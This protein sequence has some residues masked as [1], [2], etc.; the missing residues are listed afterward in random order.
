MNKSIDEY[1][2]IQFGEW[3]DAS[4]KN[5]GR[6][7]DPRESGEH[8]IKID[9]SD[10]LFYRTIALSSLKAVLDKIVD[11]EITPEDAINETR[12][13]KLNDNYTIYMWTERDFE[14]ECVKVRQ[15]L[16]RNK[17]F[18]V[19]EGPIRTKPYSG[20]GGSWLN[21]ESD[22]FGT[23]SLA[24]LDEWPEGFVLARWHGRKIGVAKFSRALIEYIEKNKVPSHIDVEQSMNVVGGTFYDPRWD[25]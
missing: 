2:A 3:I 19:T 10:S 6:V 25:K 24:R 22:G 14:E 13:L 18:I 16:S 15:H 7:I 4:Q 1:I 23:G 11:G 21:V 5:L 20:K 12:G 17:G 8:T 9:E